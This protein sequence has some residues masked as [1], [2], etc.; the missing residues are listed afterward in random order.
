MLLTN[1]LWLADEQ[2][3]TDILSR[4]VFVQVTNDPRFYP[5]QPPRIEHPGVAYADA[6]SVMIPLG[7]FK[8]QKHAEVRSLKA[9]A[10]FNLRSATRS[11][12]DVRNAVA[13]L[14]TRSTSGIGG[15]C[16]PSITPDGTVVAG[17]SRFCHKIGT[18]DSTPEEITQALTSMRCSQCGLLNSLSQEHKRAIGESLLYIPHERFR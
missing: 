18:V 15:L 6:L 3:K 13:I 14:R 8:G 1:G 16:T 10:C 4:K 12:G 17:E 2:R 9:P 11:T 5:K 7:R